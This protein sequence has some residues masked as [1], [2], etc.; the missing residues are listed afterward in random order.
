MEHRAKQWL[1]AVEVVVNS[2][3]K[4]NWRGLREEG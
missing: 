3:E 4:R 1:V 2:V